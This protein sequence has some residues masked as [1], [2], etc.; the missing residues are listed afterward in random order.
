MVRRSFIYQFRLLVL[1]A[2]CSGLSSH[3]L[4]ARAE[5]DAENPLDMETVQVTATRIA[6][7]IEKLPAL[8][9]VVTGAELEAIGAWD[10]RT[11]MSLVAGIDIAPGGDGG[12]AASV[13]GLWG[14]RE[15]DAFLLV[16]DGVPW[17]GAFNP[18]LAT[19]RLFNVDRI[20]V[21]R[22]SAPVMYGATSFVGVIHI[23]HR[24]AGD[25]DKQARLSYGSFDTASVA[26]A[27][28]LPQ[29]ENY[30]HSLSLEGETRGFADERAGVDR[31]HVLYRGALDTGPG[32]LLLDFSLAVVNQ[33]PNSPHLREGPVLAPDLPLDANYNPSDA[34]LDQDLYHFAGTYERKL[35]SL[36]SSTTLSYSHSSYDIL[37]GFLDEEYVDDGSSLNAAGYAQDR[38]TGG[39]YF[40]THLLQRLGEGTHLIYGVD[41]LYG[42]GD[43]TSDNFDYYVPSDGAYAPPGDSRPI[44]E[45]IV[46]ADRRNFYGAYV[47]LA[48]QLAP[49]WDL[50]AG[51]R[52]NHTAESR[53]TSETTADGAVDGGSD[54]LSKTR[55]SGMLGLSWRA[56]QDGGEFVSLYANY[57][58]TYKPAAIDFGPEA[59]SEI[60]QPETAV[61]Y[62]IGIKSQL[63]GGR[64]D[65]DLSLFDMRFDNLVVTQSVDGRPGLTNAGKEHFKGVEL[66]SRYRVSDDL[67]LVGNYAWHDARF[68]D[69]EQLFGDNLTQLDGNRLEM[70]P[71]NLAALGLIYHRQAGLHASLVWNY[72]G[73]R[74]MNKRNTVVTDSYDT[75]DASLGYLVGQWDFSLVGYNL[76]DERPPVAESELGES[77]YY[78]LPARSVEAF[79]T[80][81]F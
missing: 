27:M 68:G 10:L 41:Y 15:F 54:R 37:R 62:E 14:L 34:R 29:G 51:V 55:P 66:E 53:R 32:H 59:E 7:P 65:F 38:E 70:S 46:L 78:R 19:V 9:S 3:S 4:T 48:M 61:S 73:D 81:H 58:N 20:E 25:A 13:P 22:G 40:D 77:Q 47:Q 49:A 6:L 67:L 28:D 24:A 52:L 80:R 79:A 35:G 75:W 11:A 30:A 43:Q 23:I 72:I 63:A 39:V 17:G 33:D 21:L 26:A 1:C 56:W 18:E 50:L 31:G 71:K 45:T 60:L 36:D 57:R 44:E 42:K 2:A 76:S 69:Y 8:I 64:L 74:F 16:V 12:P 5:T